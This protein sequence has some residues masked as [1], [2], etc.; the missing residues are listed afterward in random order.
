MSILEL[1]LHQT[2]EI[3]AKS[4]RDLYGKPTQSAGV[5]VK[6]RFQEGTKMTKTPAGQ[7]MSVDG[8]FWVMPTVAVKTDDI[9][10][11]DGVKY[12]VVKVSKKVDLAGKPDH[13]KGYVVYV[14][15]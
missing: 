2:A 5:T 9:M 12:R 1:Y 4:G 14:T 6:C 10:T 8:E 15:A 3:A 11:V 13:I 7:E